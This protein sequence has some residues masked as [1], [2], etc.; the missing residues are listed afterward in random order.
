MDLDKE[1]G[2][3]HCDA[4]VSLVVLCATVNVESDRL[5][6]AETPRIFSTNKAS[7]GKRS[8]LMRKTFSY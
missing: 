5:S 6:F 7:R 1:P 4:S 8:A 3:G 2:E